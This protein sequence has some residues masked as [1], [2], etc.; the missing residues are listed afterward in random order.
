MKHAQNYTIINTCTKMYIWREAIIFKATY[1]HH[2]SDRYI[3]PHLFWLKEISRSADTAGACFPAVSRLNTQ[4]ALCA[5]MS[6]CMFEKGKMVLCCF[7]SL[8]LQSIWLQLEALLLFVCMSVWSPETANAF[9]SVGGS[10]M[11][12][13]ER[14]EG[15][16]NLDFNTSYKWKCEKAEHCVPKSYM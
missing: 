1:H 2:L 10:H 3:Y 12:V 5:R 11:C 4:H 8:T 14:R 6:L 16:F 7:S 13:C 15:G 9:W